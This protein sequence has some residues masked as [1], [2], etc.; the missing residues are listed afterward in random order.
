M[1]VAMLEGKSSDPD[2]FYA[3]R[4]KA[5]RQ[6]IAKRLRKVCSEYPEEE[7]SRLVDEMAARQLSFERGRNGYPK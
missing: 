1:P 7:F 5:I 2:E 4:R 6:D 3:E